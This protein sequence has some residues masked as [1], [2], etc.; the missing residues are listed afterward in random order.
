MAKEKKEKTEIKLPKAWASMKR[1][2]ETAQA[3][4]NYK[5]I[6]TLI[7]GVITLA[8]ILFIILGGVNQRKLWETLQNWAINVGNTVAG[9]FGKGDIEVN[10][11]GIYWRPNGT[12]M[13]DANGSVITWATDENGNTIEPSV[14]TEAPSEGETSEQ[15]SEETVETPTEETV[16]DNAK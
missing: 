16:E 11:D 15:P 13:T 4:E 14:E 3:R 1:R 7:T 5:G 6:W 12:T 10:D 2:N 8:I 9:W